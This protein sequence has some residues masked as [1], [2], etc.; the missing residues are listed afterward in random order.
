MTSLE[1]FRLVAPELSNVS[2]TDV[3]SMIE[4]ASL[5]ISK[6][7]YKTLYEKALAYYAAHILTLN[8]LTGDDGVTSAY[9]IK[10]EKEGDLSR[11]YAVSDSSSV[12]SYE[13]TKYGKELKRLGKLNT[14]SLV[15][16]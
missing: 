4:L 12:G 9:P 11:T 3:N 7:V 16:R 14:I 15:V 2:D 10:S 13:A 1:I 5:E 8:V 6:K